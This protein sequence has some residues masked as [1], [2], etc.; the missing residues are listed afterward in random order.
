LL[1]TGAH[2]CILN[3]AVADFV[4]DQLAESLGP[5]AVET[6]LGRVWGPLYRHTI[7]LIV[8]EGESLDLD[9]VV[10]VPPDWHAPCFLGYAGALEHAR[11]AIN[12][13]AN[14]FYFGGV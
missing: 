7:T 1:D 11:F 5:F 2:Y 12:P 10:F 3:A 9:A 4:G 6:A 8:E 14:R 13:H